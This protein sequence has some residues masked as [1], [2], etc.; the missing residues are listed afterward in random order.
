LKSEGLDTTRSPQ[1]D[2]AQY[3]KPFP[4]AQ[5]H[6]ALPPVAGGVETHLADFTRLLVN[7]GH[8]VTLFTGRGKFEDLPHVSTVSCDLLDMDRYEEQQE[9]A[10]DEVLADRLAAELGEELKQRN[11]RVVHGHNLH[12]FTPIPA[13]ALDRLQKSMGLQL[14]HTYHSIWDHGSDDHIARICSSWPGQHAISQYIKDAC[15]EKFD[16]CT[17]HT[18]TGVALD[19][20]HEVPALRAESASTDSRDQVVLLPARLMLEKGAELAV[21]MLRRLRAE[22]LPV[23]LILTSPTQT[24]DW[25]GKSEAFR[26]KIEAAVA[27][28][29]LGPYVELRSASFAEMPQLYAESDIVIYPSLYPEPLGLAPL[30]AAAMGRPVVVT[31]IGGLPETV[32][33][34]ETGYIIPPNDLEALTDRVRTLLKDPELAR[35]MGQAGK[36]HVSANFALESYVDRMVELYRT[37]PA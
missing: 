15:F 27:G 13:M 5:V 9:Y 6:W 11:I 22:N 21:R 14:H 36:A 23:R 1:G 16:I 20:F 28:Y 32:R 4:I 30:E 3:S 10:S 24:V 34:G 2:V 31:R 19:R 29:G 8:E 25:D 7:R 18:F 33:D 26:Q 35:R 12:Y 17:I 37:I